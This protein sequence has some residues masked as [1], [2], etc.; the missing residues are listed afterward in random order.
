[1]G[2]CFSKK[3]PNGT[4]KSPDP[5]KSAITIPLKPETEAQEKKIEIEESK[6]SNEEENLKTRKEVFVIKHRKSHELSKT[7]D[8]EDSP[9]KSTDSNQNP[10]DVDA[11]LIQCGR[12]SRSN[13][14]AA[15]TR[16]YSGSKRSFDGGDAEEADVEDGGE[17]EEAER[18]IHRNRN[19]GG[20]SPRDRRRR[21]PSREREDS[22]GYRSGSR[23]RGSSGGGSRRVSRSPGRRSEI[24]VKP[25]GSVSSVN[26]SDNNRPTRFVS[27]PATEKSNNGGDPS[28]KRIAVKRNVASPRSQS[29][30]RAASQPS[31]SKLSRKN[32]RSPYRR[33]PL[34]EIDVNSMQ[35]DKLGS[36]CNKR[37]M[38][39]ENES[40]GLAQKLNT[41]TVR[42]AP[43]RRSASPIRVIK[44]QQQEA[45]EECKIVL[46]SVAEF[47][48]PQTVSRSRSLRKS[49][50]FDFS[51]EVLLSNNIESN[52]NTAVAAAAAALPSY[53]ALLLE[54]IQNFTQK[55]VIVNTIP[56]SISKACSIVEAVGDLNSTTKK[57]QRTESNNFTSA[58][59]KNAD[60]T[61]PRFEKYVTVKR[62]SS[63]MEE[64]EPQESSGSNSFT[65]SSGVVQQSPSWEPNS[66]ES[67]DRVSV[68]SKKQ[69]R[70]RSPLGLNVEKQ[71]FDPLMKNGIGVGHKRVA[72]VGSTQ[73]RV[74]AVSM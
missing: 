57:H 4:V 5:N 11:I 19:R 26:S 32:E 10:V 64:M 36:N 12:L 54:D 70:D 18:R 47:P 8:P 46:T 27:V 49:R 69:E 71:E 28:I 9:E 48:K 63:S 2:C 25:T 37:M 65:G 58:L 50:D 24:N 39:T 1:M 51:P 38:K 30:A 16:R 60:L 13:S 73:V 55:S 67:T 3:T 61:E 40:H 42:Q 66:A 6:P 17:E 41:K 29:P 45:V 43:I 44:E 53:T 7:T 72:L 15:K 20:E 33:N 21:T 62:G 68:R 35:G 52:N 59:A 14:A 23:E 22:K 74:A 56:S 34:G 31:P